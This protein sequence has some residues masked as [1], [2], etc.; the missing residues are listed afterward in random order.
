M[1]TNDKLIK[2]TFLGML[3]VGGVSTLFSIACIMVDAIMTGQFL[4]KEAVAASGL[5]QPL[6]MII[7]LVG[8]LFGPGLAVV[9]TRYMGMAK[10]DLVNRTFTLVIVVL[11]CASIVI[12]I[13]IFIFSSS[14]AD[15]LLGAQASKGNIALLVSDYLK[16]FSF[17][18]APMYLSI[19]LSGLMMLDND[20]TRAILGML[21]TLICDFAFDYINVKVF[22]GGMFGMAIATALSNLAGLI[23]VWTH[24]LKKNRILHFNF[25]KLDIK[26]LKDVVLSGISNSVTMGSVAVRGFCFNAFFL[27]TTGEMAVAALSA[28]N[29]LFS[30]IN[31]VTLAMFVTTS[32]L[33]SLLFG[34]GDGN[35][36]V[37]TL[38]I[39]GKIIL[40][41]FGVITIILLIAGDL[42]AGLFLDPSA[43]EQISQAGSFIRF[44]AVQYLFLALSF[45]ISGTYQGLGK[46][47][48]SYLILALKECVIPILCSIILGLAFGTLGF[49]IGLVVSGILVL[50]MCYLIPAIINKKLSIKAKDVA[51]LPESIKLMPEQLFE[52]SVQEDSRIVE[53]SEEART[54]C[55]KNGMSKREAMLTS[56]FIEE[57]LMNI[58][59]HGK[60]NSQAVQVDLRVVR[61][62]G[63]LVIRFRDNGKPFNPVDWYEKNHPEDLSSGLGI[64]M[65][66]GLAKDVNYVPAMGLNNLMLTL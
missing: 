51:L 36:I 13:L 4:G 18:V 41:L 33:V 7:N 44:M 42:F 66:V 58:I 64:R 19:S 54:F 48:L 6:V 53:V 63:S 49:E 11:S 9:C 34:E 38:R 40:G 56:L 12:G 2:K 20:R 37:R 62:D 39:S 1:N 30:I 23:V 21:V 22:E 15:I 14:I 57:N 25:E 24:F 28:A 61:R 59:T 16:G 31:A 32:S 55:I 8:G 3:A 46:N 52:A 10:K 17:A 35:S 26:L 5:I 50:I 60:K 29:S 27:A 45:S 47:R 43:V 65:I